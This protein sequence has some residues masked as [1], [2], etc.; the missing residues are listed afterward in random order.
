MSTNSTTELF[1]AL[2]RSGIGKE[3]KLPGTPSPEQ[4]QELFD[5]SKKQTLAGITFR[6]IENLP[7]EQRP[8][9]NLL[10]QWYMLC[11]S[12]KKTNSSLNRKAATISQKFREEGFEN[13]ILKGQGIAR[14][15]PDPQ[16]RTPGDIDIWLG[17][18][19][20]KVLRYVRTI[21][22]DCKPTYHHVDFNISGDVDIE[23]HY[24]PTWM[25]NPFINHRLQNYFAAVAKEQFTNIACTPEGSFPVATTQFNRIYILLHIYRHLF[26]EGIGIRQILD[27]YF[28]TTQDITEEEKSEHIRHL[29]QFGLYKFARAVTYV[30]QQMFALDEQ[31]ML[32]TPDSKEG[33]FLIGEIMAAG[34]F[35]QH[36]TRY[37]ATERGINTARVQD[38]IRRSLLLFAHYPS[39]TFWDPL[40]KVWHLLWRKHH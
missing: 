26:F 1:F 24:R 22:P 21:T 14:L 23:I 12:I 9:K 25:C 5:M 33:E 34:N 38:I 32:V 29:K 27:Y 7:Q 10:L 11:E 13:S 35:G 40:F 37:T 20:D 36:D 16:L 39:E 31:H 6:G 3:S 18:G 28:V 2:I 4:W 19:C 17:G 30:M 15:Y 8:P